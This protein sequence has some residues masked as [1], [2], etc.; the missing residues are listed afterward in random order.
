MSL[1]IWTPVSG[2]TK[3]ITFGDPTLR[4]LAD[5]LRSLTVTTGP[6]LR[7]VSMGC[8]PVFIVPAPVPTTEADAFLRGIPVAPD[9]G[10]VVAGAAGTYTLYS[11]Y[12]ALALITTEGTLT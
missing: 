9:S 6:H 5:K 7:F 2:T 3:L 4:T 8:H 1:G 12:E 11:P 10:V